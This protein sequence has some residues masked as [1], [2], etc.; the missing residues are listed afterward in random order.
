MI[1]IRQELS[2]NKTGWQAKQVIWILSIKRQR[3]KIPQSTYLQTLLHKWGFSAK[4][5][6]KRVVNTASK[7]E[8]KRLSK[9]G[10]R[11]TLANPK[12][13]H[14]IAVQDESIFVHIM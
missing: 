14:H 12:R 11:I 2:E 8:R 5:P 10:T 4:V 9:R 7:E 13:I 6:Q 1:K 3:C